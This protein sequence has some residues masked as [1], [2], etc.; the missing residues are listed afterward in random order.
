MSKVTEGRAQKAQG[1]KRAAANPNEEHPASSPCL[2][3][4]EP[5]SL[6]R[7]LR[8]IAYAPVSPLLHL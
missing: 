2:A 5:P 8:H 6:V 4:R 3:V 7:K 1:D